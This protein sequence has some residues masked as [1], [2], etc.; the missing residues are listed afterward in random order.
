[1]W[2]YKYPGKLQMSQTQARVKPNN[3]RHM[4]THVIYLCSVQFGLK[5]GL[6][7]SARPMIFLG[8]DFKQELVIMLQYVHIKNCKET[9]RTKLNL[10]SCTLAQVPRPNINP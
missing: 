4:Q 3:C 1:M 10:C 9:H 5:P 6:D 7:N 8:E 2:R